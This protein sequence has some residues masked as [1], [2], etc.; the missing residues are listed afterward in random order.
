MIAMCGPFSSFRILQLQRCAQGSAS[1]LDDITTCS[2][3]Y[4]FPPQTQLTYSSWGSFHG[5]ETLRNL[6]EESEDTGRGRLS[7][8]SAYFA[9]YRACPLCSLC[10]RKLNFLAGSFIIHRYCSLPPRL[11]SPDV[12][13][14]FS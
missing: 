8:I 10:V 6:G 5:P 1:V 13:A 3:W 11:L 7:R 14:S 9:Q 2:Y 4:A 12:G